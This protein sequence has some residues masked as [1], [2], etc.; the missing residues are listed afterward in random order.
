L[1]VN[2]DGTAHATHVDGVKLETP[3]QMT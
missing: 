1:V 3:I 2:E